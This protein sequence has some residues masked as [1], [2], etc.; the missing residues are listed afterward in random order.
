MFISLC[1]RAFL[2]CAGMIWHYTS[3]NTYFLNV[4]VYTFEKISLLQNCKGDPCVT[5]KCGCHLAGLG[6]MIVL[7]DTMSK[8]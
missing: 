5:E 8:L 1:I 3:V 7:N 6:R 4:K 2:S